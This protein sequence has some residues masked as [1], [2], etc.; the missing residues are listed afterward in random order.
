MRMRTYVL[1]TIL[2]AGFIC[3]KR[4]SIEKS[5]SKLVCY[6]SNPKEIDFCKCTHVVVPFDVNVDSIDNFKDSLENTKVLLSV[7]DLNE[8]RML[9]K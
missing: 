2:T 8:V 4:C 6:Y 5:S 1:V 3:A 9:L 7:Q